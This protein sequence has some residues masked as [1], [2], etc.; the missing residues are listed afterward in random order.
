ML[1]A[2]NRMQNALDLAGRLVRLGLASHL[3]GDL[4]VQDGVFLI[5]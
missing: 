1:G 2:L 5:G 3:V 4:E